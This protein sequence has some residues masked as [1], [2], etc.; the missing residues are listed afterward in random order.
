MAFEELKERQSVMWGS[1]PFENYVHWLA[2]TAES[3]SNP[4]PVAPATI[5]AS[6][7]FPLPGGP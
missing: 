5:R 7:V 3:S 2:D 6:V 1:A 4:A